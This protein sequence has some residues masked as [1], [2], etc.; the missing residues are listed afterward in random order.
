MRY[1]LCL[2]L[3][4]SVSGEAVGCDDK[5]PSQ[6]MMKQKDLEQQLKDLP[7]PKGARLRIE[8]TPQVNTGEKIGEWDKAQR[9]IV[10]GHLPDIMDVMIEQD[11]LPVFAGR[12]L[13]GEHVQLFQNLDTGVW[14]FIAAGPAEGEGCSLG[15][16]TESLALVTEYNLHL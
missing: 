11:A 4:L 10:C 14:F 2:V 3:L 6:L 8:P 12:T 15:G 16:G 7:K 1:V 13:Q 9:M 5:L